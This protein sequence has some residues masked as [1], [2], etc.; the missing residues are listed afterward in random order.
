ME[1]SELKKMNING[2]NNEISNHV[3]VYP[4]K[5]FE[6]IDKN[7][8]TNEQGNKLSDISNT[9]AYAYPIVAKQNQIT[10]LI[11]NQKP[12]KVSTKKFY[13][14]PKSITCPYCLKQI[15]TE[16]ET[17]CN[18]C[19]CISCF[20]LFIFIFPLALFAGFCGYCSC[21][22]TEKG[23]CCGCNCCCRCDCERCCDGNCCYDGVHKCPNCKRI[24]YNYNSCTRH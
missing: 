14:Y 10:Q 4:K 17:S 15:K 20:L 21:I 22:C 7:I 16:V 2:N 3:S 6:R 8:N 11:D 12:I 18:I 5:K 1:H 13:I 24:I 19:T 23:C 9:L